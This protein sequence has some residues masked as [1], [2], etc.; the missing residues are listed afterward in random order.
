MIS[1]EKTISALVSSQLPDFIRADHPKFKRFVELYYTWL[2]N[3]SKTG[4]S[5]TAGNTIYHAMNMENYRN[6]DETPDEFV[7]YFKEEL[8]PHFPEKS[9]L[10]IKKLLKNAR[11]YYSKKGSEESLKWLFKVLYNIDIEVN[12]PKDEILIASDGKWKNPRAFRITVSESNKNLNVNLLN[13]NKVLG[14]ES[15]ATCIIESANRSIDETNGVE[16]I[17][18][19]ISNITKYF[20][21]GEIIEIL[22]TDEIGVQRIFREKI[23]GTLSNIRVDSNIRTDPTQRRRGLLYNVGDPVVIT[24]GL[25]SSPEANDAAA[26]VGNVTR[27]SIEAVT[28]IFRGYGYREFPNTQVIVL[29]TIGIDDDESN[30]ST[31]LR[32]LAL[33]LSACTANSQRNFLEQIKYDKTVIDFSSSTLLASSNFQ[34]M[35]PKNY[36]VLLNVSEE[37]YTD[38]FD[39]FEE[40]Y[41]SNNSTTNKFDSIFLGKVATP[42]GQ[43]A[44]SGL[45]NVYSTNGTVWGSNTLFSFEL[46]V[47]QILRVDSEDRI[48]S[49]ITNNEH[50]IVDSAYTSTL[51]SQ[52][53]RRVG[54][55]ANWVGPNATDDLLIYEVKNSAPL[56][57]LTAE[58]GYL[59]AVNSGKTWEVNSITNDSIDAN[60]NSM[61]AQA[62]DYKIAN[63]GGIAAITVINGGFGFRTEPSLDIKTHYDTDLSEDYNYNNQRELKTDNWQTFKDLGF[64]AHVYINFGG[65][66]YSVGDQLV[67]TGRGYG[68]KGYVQTITANGAISSILLENRGEGYL[69]RPE[70]I[71]NRS[72]TSFTQLTG[73]TSVN[74]ESNIVIG[75]GT[76]FI[77]QLSTLNVIRINNEIKK[78]TQVVNNAFLVTNTAFTSNATNQSIFR[79]NGTEAI[80]TGYLVGDGFEDTIDTSA[81]GRVQDIRLLYRGFDYVATP[82]VSLKVVDTVVYPIPEEQELIEQEYVYQGDSFQTST[83]RANVKS[84][85]K[86]TNLLRLYNYSGTID[87]NKPIKSSNAFIININNT[88]RV[89]VPVRGVL[90]GS[91]PATFYPPTVSSLPNPM[92]YG[93]GRA[94]AS[95]LF[96]NGLIEFNGFYLNTDGFVSADKVL[97]D[98][99]IYHNF[100]YVIQ[101]EKDLIEY[102]STIKNITH[103]AGTVL[104]AK[105]ISQSTDNTAIVPTSNADVFLPKYD[106]S[107]ITILDSKSNVVT[108]YGTDFTNSIGANTTVNIGD[109]LILQY[110]KPF[111][112]TQIGNTSSPRDQ[113]K[114]ITSVNS[115]TE[116]EVESNF[117]LVG[118]GKANSNVL[119]NDITG[120]VNTNPAVSGTVNINSRISGT[121]NVNDR[122]IGTANVSTNNIV[123]GN[124]TTFLQNLVANSIITINNQPKLIVN[125]TNNQH[126]IVNSAFTN[127]GNDEI[128]YLTNTTVVGTGTSFLSDL[129]I[130]DIVTINGE[131]RS[132]VSI[133]NSTRLE[134][135]TSFS[136]HANTANLYPRS[137][138][139]IGNQTNFD[140]QI[141]VG[142]LITINNEIR[143]VTVIVDDDVL[144]VNSVFLHDATEQLLFKENTT[145]AGIGT[146]FTSEL[147]ANDIIKVNN[148]IRE[149][150]TITDNETLTV[151]S[152]FIYFGELNSISKLSNTTLEIKGNNNTLSDIIV[153]GDNILFN[154][155]SSNVYKQKSGTVSI[156]TTELSVVGTSTNFD[157]EFQVGDYVSINNI[158]R[159]II[160]ISDST[161]M[162]VN[163][164][165]DINISESLVFKRETIKKSNVISVID[166]LITLNTAIESNTQNLVWLV[167]PNYSL[168]ITLEGTVNIT[169]GDVVVTGNTTEPNTTFFVGNV[170]VG[171]QINVNNETRIVAAVTNN[172]TL[173]VTLPFNND[174]EDKYL[175]TTQSYDYKVITITKDF[176]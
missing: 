139:V 126:L 164:P 116:L 41:W 54:P 103:P 175:R 17:E 26:F 73:T 83:F 169:S 50:L 28:P 97:Q 91:G 43:T 52:I 62:L 144:E 98:N 137:S 147:T 70:I 155:A 7:R 89:P 92:Y 132:I 76:N 158:V 141:N 71:V 67:F 85:N 172:D 27:G 128:I 74:N 176:G 119:Y 1:A 114:I 82:T 96:S 78:I 95:A 150:I 77:N 33:N 163:S 171:M 133:S 15:G 3:N 109:L 87:I 156:S 100:S 68:A 123:I 49:S 58:S 4:I 20:N 30:S 154:I 34:S 8:L 174:A 10:D 94:K 90:V 160:D 104:T 44:I 120:S 162:N 32:V 66:G 135:N 166:K 125:I 157:N 12:Y 55:F 69:S 151:N 79:Q 115:N 64:I 46:K 167:E 138:I 2:E 13:R 37:D 86:T 143:E 24:G 131:I 101:A 84:Y 153:P 112:E 99:K 145:I 39:N 110:T 51:T 81:I 161:L 173:Q 61:I 9:S 93:N 130:G 113:T 88:V 152:P 111:F 121:V 136:N 140:P 42:N 23:I 134:V 148:Q 106:S 47:N 80:L 40:V 22:Y 48:I 6:I 31:D 14:T 36:N 107:R 118:Q 142:D 124:N 108:G 35:T 129:N 75:E 56:T 149:V 19:Y 5:N 127:A 117:I 11:E 57:V 59:V 53:A 16:V 105:R 146:A 65:T 21:N 159:Q 168:P 165:F 29:R 170:V 72:L 122:I 18:I 63:T 102:E 25:S 45:V 38:Y 60:I